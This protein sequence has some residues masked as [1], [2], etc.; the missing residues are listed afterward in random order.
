M[1]PSNATAAAAQMGDYMSAGALLGKP[2]FMTMGNHECSNSHTPGSDCSSS[3]S[4]DFK[5]GAFL[6]ALKN[7]SSTPYYRID[8][9]TNAGLAVFIVIADD[10]W[11][12]TQSAWL[13]QQLTD[14]DAHA[15][16]TF[17]SRHHP[18]G[19]T[20][21]T[22]FADIENIVHAHKYTLF[23]TGHSHLYRRSTSDPREVVMGLGGAPFDGSQSW[24]GYGTV[25][26][27]PDDYIY[28]TLYDQATGNVEDSFAVPPQ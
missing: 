15:K 25:M 8:V 18:T 4:S 5:C 9:K 12:S 27:C 19:N 6:N 1:E 11:N 22:F 3:C 26:Q 10:A 16:Y 28:V 14:A 2:L 17:L 21:Q 24:W 13:T 20:E 23:L 7:V